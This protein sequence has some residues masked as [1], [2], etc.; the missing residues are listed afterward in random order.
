MNLTTNLCKDVPKRIVPGLGN[1]KIVVRFVFSQFHTT[2][3]ILPQIQTERQQKTV[4]A[5]S[6]Y[7]F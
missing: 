3:L 2:D 5:F 4:F 1:E 7:N 6:S